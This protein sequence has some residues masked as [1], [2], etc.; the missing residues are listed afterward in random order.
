[1]PGYWYSCIVVTAGPPG[2]C[3]GVLSCAVW[4]PQPHTL[5]AGRNCWTLLELLILP[6]RELA[7]SFHINL[8]IELEIWTCVGRTRPVSTR[9]NPRHAS[10]AAAGL[11]N[12]HYRSVFY[13]S[14]PGNRRPL[15]YDSQKT[16]DMVAKQGPL[17]GGDPQGG[18][19]LIPLKNAMS[20]ALR[21]YLRKHITLMSYFYLYL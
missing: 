19:H 21:K 18:G 20:V 8:D 7:A 15:H 11:H 3:C 2:M 17:V 1:M 13:T 16:L 9:S 12:S 5:V 14:R 6:R 4:R 10:N